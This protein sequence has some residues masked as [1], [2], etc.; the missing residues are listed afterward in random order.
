MQIKELILHIYLLFYVILKST[1]HQPFLSMSKSLIKALPELVDS[2][3]ISEKTAEDI[4]DFYRNKEEA[5][6]N[7]LL[8]VFGVLGAILVGLGI[9]LIIAHNWDVLSR[10]TK[11]FFSFLPLVMGQALCAFVLIKKREQVTWRESTAVFLFF[12][13]GASISLISQVYHISGNLS[14]FLLTWM[15]LGLPLIYI[16]RSSVVALFYLM[17]ITCYACET[18]YWTYPSSTPYL[19]WLLLLLAMPQYY[20]LWR[21][22]PE[23][24]FTI[25]HHWFVPLSVIITL[26]TWASSHEELMFIAYISLFAAFYLIG[27][28]SGLQTQK[29]MHNSYQL[30][31]AAG[32]L[33]LL[34]FLSFDDFWNRLY[35]EHLSLIQVVNSVE[36]YVALVLSLAAFVLLYS[37]YK[38]HTWKALELMDVVFLLFI[39]IFLSGILVL[40]LPAVLMNLLVLLLGISIIHHGA[41]EHHLGI[42]NYGLLVITVLVICR[43]FD[44]NLS[45]VVRGILF[46]LVGVG[47]FL[48]NYQMV[49]KKKAL[50]K[51]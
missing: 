3:V 36:F 30:L 15:L 13:V 11:T 4:R 43:F 24:N 46:V 10:G 22:K 37:H 44:V 32:L 39:F 47:F 35:R 48:A 26:G 7:R 50:D 40:L 2:A 34:L 12:A 31:G 21:Q 20:L 23:S 14:S 19:Y 17:G 1:Q 9:I 41:K 28:Q 8:I 27:K 6:P 51:K 49:Q 38:Q 16:M 5:N 45:F 42:L 33:C 18:G 29:I 25:W